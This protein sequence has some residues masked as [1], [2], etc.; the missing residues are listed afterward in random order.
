[1]D[2]IIVLDFTVWDGILSENNV[3]NATLILLPAM[4]YVSAIFA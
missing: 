2:K 3:N 1:M 4:A